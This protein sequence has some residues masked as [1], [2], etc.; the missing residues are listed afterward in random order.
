MSARRLRDFVRPRHLLLILDNFEQIIAAGSFVAELL[1][2]A[3]RLHVLITSR[4]PLHVYGEHEFPLMPLPVPDLAALPPPDQLVQIPSVMLLIERARAVKPNFALTP[5]NALA[6]AAI[7]VRLDGLPLAIELAAAQSKDAVAGG[8]GRE[9]G[10]S[11]G[12]ADARSAQS[13]GPP[14]NAAG[15]HRVE[16]R[17]VGR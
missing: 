14:A 11:A 8:T 5:T 9:A 15:R 16:F 17:S 7:V 2:A 6:L 13:I 10:Q 4:T 3:P 1:E 12:D